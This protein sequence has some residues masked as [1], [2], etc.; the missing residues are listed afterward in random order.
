VAL[1]MVNVIFGISTRVIIL[2]SDSLPAIQMNGVTI[3]TIQQKYLPEGSPES[4][5]AS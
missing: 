5:E 1:S 4:E 3:A 2:W